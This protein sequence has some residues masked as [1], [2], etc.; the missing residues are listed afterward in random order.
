MKRYEIKARAIKSTRAVDLVYEYECE[1]RKFSKNEAAVV[2]KKRIKKNI[3][4]PKKLLTLSVIKI[5]WDL[6]KVKKLEGI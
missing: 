1:Y 5:A 6:I 3:V 2:E 4:S